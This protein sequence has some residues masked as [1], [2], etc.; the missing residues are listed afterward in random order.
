GLTLEC[1][2]PKDADWTTCETWKE[3]RMVDFACGSGSLLIAMLTE[4]KRRAVAQGADSHQISKLQKLAVE[5][6]ICGLDINPVSLQLAASQLTAGNMDVVYRRMCLYLMEYGTSPKTGRTSAGSLELL[7]NSRILER[8]YELKL[9]DENSASQRMQTGPNFG[10]KPEHENIMNDVLNTRIAIMNP[11]FTNR[12]KMGEKFPSDEK[13]ALRRRG[14]ALFRCLEGTVLGNCDVGNTVHPMF[15]TL[16]DACLVDNGVMAFVCPTI[17]LTAPSGLEERIALASNYNVHTVLVSVATGQR[18]M[19]NGTDIDEALVVLSKKTPNETF[20]LPTRVIM[21]DRFPA[22]LKESS[23]LLERILEVEET[24]IIRD[25]WGEVSWWPSERIKV[26]D[27]GAVCFR[28]QKLREFANDCLTGL[29]GALTPLASDYGISNSEGGGGEKP[30]ENWSKPLRQ[31]LPKASGQ[32]LRGG[33]YL[34]Q[35]KKNSTETIS[36]QKHD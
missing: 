27:W 18:N 34:R 20:D 5:E 9:E 15:I 12:S 1:A 13:K 29:K 6:I 2:M 4:M 25:G 16:A 33:P 31:Y 32:V 21:L 14:D 8:K 19:S 11:P 10:D 30:V 3:C 36:G 22:D 24:D 23:E 28:Q 26:G 35:P 7:A 17:A